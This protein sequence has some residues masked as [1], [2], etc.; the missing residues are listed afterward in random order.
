VRRAVAL[1][2]G[3]AETE[4]SGGVTLDTV[5]QYAECGVDYISVGEITHS[6]P[7]VDFS[8]EIVEG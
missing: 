3:R 5:R 1:V 6:A 2:A 4:V 7:A 8:L